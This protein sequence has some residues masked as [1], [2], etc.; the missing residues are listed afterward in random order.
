MKNIS[1]KVV[2]GVILTF[3]TVCAIYLFDDLKHHALPVMFAFIA[4]LP[5]LVSELIVGRRNPHVG[6]HVR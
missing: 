5:L 4:A 6:R 2:V 3:A 1:E